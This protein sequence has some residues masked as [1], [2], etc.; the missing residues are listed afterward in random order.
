MPEKKS[1][2][3][4]SPT[5]RGK[6]RYVKFRLICSQ[7]LQEKGV[8]FSLSNTFSSLFGGKGIAEQRLWLVKWFPGKNEGILRCSLQEEEDVKAGILFISRVGSA[9]VIP[10]IVK[11]SGSI[12]K[13]K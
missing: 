1:M 3:P 5:L 4:I 8:W 11:V 9:Q 6:K 7:A 13:L 2:K 12:K 10:T